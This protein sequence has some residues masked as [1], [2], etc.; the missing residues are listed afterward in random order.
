MA[1]LLGTYE[2]RDGPGQVPWHSR[3]ALGGWAAGVR[4][5][6]GCGSPRP[7]V[8]V[9]SASAADKQAGSLR[10]TPGRRCY[11]RSE[12]RTEKRRRLPFPWKIFSLDT[13]SLM[14]V[15]AASRE[16]VVSSGALTGNAG[17]A[18]SSR[19]LE[20]DDRD[21]RLG[22]VGPSRDTIAAT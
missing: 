9:R 19:G 3:S 15:R 18:R 10:R 22:V 1:A 4:M 8:V 13:K 17:V 12:I 6:V 14:S 5:S 20:Y 7:L 21:T 16:S 11:M 2:Y